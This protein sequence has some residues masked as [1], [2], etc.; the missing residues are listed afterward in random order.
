[1]NGN[2]LHLPSTGSL[3]AGDYAIASI[4]YGGPSPLWVQLGNPNQTLQTVSYLSM[5]TPNTPTA[6]GG[7]IVSTGYLDIDVD[8]GVVFSV[9][10]ISYGG[11]LTGAGLG[12]KTVDHDDKTKRFVTCRAYASSSFTDESIGLN[13]FN[14]AGAYFNGGK[15]DRDAMAVTTIT[16]S[17]AAP[18][19]M[20]VIVFDNASAGAITL[21][22]ATGSGEYKYYKCV[23]A[24]SVTIEGSS[25]DTI[26]GSANIVISQWEKMLLLDY[27]SGKW[28]IL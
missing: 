17:C 5:T 28:I 3:Y 27:E 7:G 8:G 23:G 1:M 25:S 20:K 14:S 18:V 21:Q 9:I 26:D 22:S 24:G 13:L 19:S 2:D 11:G 10:P 6:K 16:S 15:I 4:F 12:W